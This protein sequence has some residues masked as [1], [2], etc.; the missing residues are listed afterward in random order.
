[1]GYCARCRHR[2]AGSCFPVCAGNSGPGGCS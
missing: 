1:M 2:T